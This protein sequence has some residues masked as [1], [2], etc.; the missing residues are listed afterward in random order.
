MYKY[1]IMKFKNYIICHKLYTIVIIIFQYLINSIYKSN[2]LCHHEIF[3][4][5]FD[6]MIYI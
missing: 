3:S 2:T 4:S 5:E 6:V 1:D